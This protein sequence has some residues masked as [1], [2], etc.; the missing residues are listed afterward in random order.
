MFY[1]NNMV[2]RNNLVYASLGGFSGE[3]ISLFSFFQLSDKVLFLKFIG[4]VIF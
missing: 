3:F 2:C 4:L 1:M